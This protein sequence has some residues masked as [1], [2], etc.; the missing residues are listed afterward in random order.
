MFNGKDDLVNCGDCGKE[1]DAEFNIYINRK[2]YYVCKE[3][4]KNYNREQ[5]RKDFWDAC[6]GKTFS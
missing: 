1:I 6:N 2:H 4:L 5:L 3:C